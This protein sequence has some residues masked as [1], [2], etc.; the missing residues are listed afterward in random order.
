MPQI[1]LEEERRRHV[2]EKQAL[3]EQS[4]Q[5]ARQFHVEQHKAGKKLKALEFNIQLKQD[6]I[7]NLVCVCTAGPKP[8]TVSTGQA[9][10]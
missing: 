5:L 8:S 7:R 1:A 10:N 2:E 9:W 6:L 4:A 3:D